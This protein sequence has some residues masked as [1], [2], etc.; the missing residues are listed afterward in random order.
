VPVGE[1][2]S[3]TAEAVAVPWRRLAP[4]RSRAG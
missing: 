2:D 4:A 1:E 3:R